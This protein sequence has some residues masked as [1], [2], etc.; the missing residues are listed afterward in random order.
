MENRGYGLSWWLR[1]KKTHLPGQETQTPSLAQEDALEEE[2]AAHSSILAGK[3][4][5]QRSLVGDSPW[6]CKRV[7]HDSVTKQQQQ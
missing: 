3:F 4:H 5:G 1:A 7:E 2:M 6:G